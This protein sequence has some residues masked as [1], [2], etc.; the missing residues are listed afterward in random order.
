MEVTGAP[1]PPLRNDLGN[2]NPLGPHRCDA[3]FLFFFIGSQRR[4]I[5]LNAHHIVSL[6]LFVFFLFVNEMNK[7]KWETELLNLIEDLLNLDGRVHLP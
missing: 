4:Q 7:D 5:F 1:A 3:H 2:P 6:L